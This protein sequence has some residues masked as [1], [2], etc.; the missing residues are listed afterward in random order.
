KYHVTARVKITPPPSSPAEA[1]FLYDSFSQLGNLEYFS[2]PRDKSGFSIYDN[3]IHLVYNPS[4]QQSLLGSAYLREE[5]HWEEGEHELRIHQKAIVDKLR[6]TIALPRYSFIK[7]DSQYYN[8]EVEIQFKHQLPLDAL[9]YD[10][11]YQ[12][13]SS[14]IESPFLTLK[15]EPEFSQIDTLRGKIRHNF[16][17][18]HKF[19]EI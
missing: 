9:K 6:H 8:G 2:I 5:A 19:D 1:K 10:K 17:K 18:F 7:D 16:Q 3:Y 12:I 4:K 13:T 15:R 14:T 11:K